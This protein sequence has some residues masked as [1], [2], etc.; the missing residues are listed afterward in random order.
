MA[1]LRFFRTS[2]RARLT[3]I[4]T[5]LLGVLLFVYGT[6]VY[7]SVSTIL[8]SQV[9]LT[10]ESAIVDTI[11][12]LR[13]NN[14]GELATITLL[15][16]DSSLNLQVFDTQGH[17]IGGTSPSANVTP[18]DPQALSAA[19]DLRR[20]VYRGDLHLRVHSVPIFTSSRG[21]IG[22]VQ[23]GIDLA[24]I[25]RLRSNLLQALVIMGL[26]AMGFSAL[27]TWFLTRRAL[28]PLATMTRTAL[29]ITRAD[30]LSR[31]I[32][33]AGNTEDEVGQLVQAFN[34]T[35][36]RLED[37]FYAQRRFIADVSHELRTPLT[38]I[39]GNA[40][41]MRRIGDTDNL[42]LYSIEAE[43]DRLTRLVGDLLL[44]AQAESGRL[45]L[46]NRVVELDTLLLE[47]FQQAHILSNG[48]KQLNI[49]EID[50][51]LVCGDADRLKQVL[52]NLVGNAVKYT[53]AGGKIDIRLWKQDGWAQLTVSDNGPGIP[54]EDLDHIFERFYRAEKSRHRSEDGKS[55]GLGL[56]IAHW[57]VHHH[58]GK[59]EVD[60]KEGEGTTFHVGLPLASGNC[61]PPLKVPVPDAPELARIN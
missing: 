50:Q 46:D 19:E 35:M 26:L 49:I 32:P 33:H 10:L 53:Q 16:Y 38:V 51:V 54:R 43:V 36:S 37:L 1:K 14:E 11:S 7:A 18:L 40:D 15:S 17:F 31:R 22:T 34:Q 3:V 58:G 48:E 56:S 20:D 60:S 59:I 30:D 9:D 57:I 13:A 27:L 39:K 12:V 25:D 21:R 8:M 47:V 4:F 55:F 29:Q 52:L 2:L 24:T 45:P 41:L 28:Q 5:L 6:A 23:A 44:L 42:S 61:P